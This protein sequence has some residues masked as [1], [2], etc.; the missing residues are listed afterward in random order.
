[1]AAQGRITAGKTDL[2]PFSVPQT[3]ASAATL[4]QLQHSDP[5]QTLSDINPGNKMGLVGRISFLLIE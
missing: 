2:L 5:F 3:T 4:H 1:M